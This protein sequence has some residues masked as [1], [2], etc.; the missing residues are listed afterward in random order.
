VTLNKS[1]RARQNKERMV[2]DRT[3]GQ[4]G[5]AYKVKAGSGARFCRI[6]RA[7]RQATHRGGPSD[8]GMPPHIVEL[9]LE[10]AVRDETR[11]PWEKLLVNE[12]VL[13]WQRRAQ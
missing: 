1:E 11:M 8:T 9:V 13:A 2:T 7:E 5:A 10:Q 6:C 3:C 4:C 12:T